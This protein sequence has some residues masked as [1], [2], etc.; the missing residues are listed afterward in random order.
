MRVITLF[1]FVVLPLATAEATGLVERADAYIQEALET[2]QIPAISAGILVDGE[3]VWTGAAGFRDLE[4][5]LPVTPETTFRI[6]SISKVLT[7]AA[8]LRA[9][10]KGLI[11]LQAPVQHYLPDYPHSKKGQIKIEHLLLHTSGIRHSKGKESRTQEHYASLRD[12]CRFFEKRRLAF[13]PGTK[14]RYTSYGYTVLGAVLE[15]A[16]GVGFEPFMQSH[17]WEPAGMEHTALDRRP[18][19]TA[20]EASLYRVEKGRLVPD[21]KNDLSL[22]Y[23]GG[24]MISTA[25][26]LLRFVDAL[27]NGTLISSESLETMLKHPVH[28]RKVLEEHGGMGWNVWDHEYHGMILS[29]VGGQSGT[30]ALLVSYRD[31]GVTA[32]VLTNVA[33]LDPIWELVNSLIGMGVEAKQGK[34]T[35]AGDEE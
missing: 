3:I 9:S 25:G 18:S 26:D 10:E 21:V 14:Y 23:P 34:V 32:V 30:S 19:D 5:R 35:G 12:A 6:A 8:V 2:H 13:T 29:R 16:G 17:V 22:I 28:N 7:A 20:G 24:G 15:S 27:E 11:D 1:A 31:K 4:K 33:Q